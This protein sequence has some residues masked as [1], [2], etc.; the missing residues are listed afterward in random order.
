MRNRYIVV[1]LLVLTALTFVGC[2]RN[3]EKAK[4]KYLDSGMKYMDNKQYEAASIQ[5][6][7]AIQVDPKFAEA[8]YQ[9]AE[10]S[11]KLEHWGEGFREMSQAVELDPNNLKA[12]IAL[13]DF[14]LAGGKYPEAEEQAKAILERDPNNAD[15]YRLLGAVQ[16][17]QKQIPEAI[18]SYTKAIAAEAR[19]GPGAYLNRG[20]AYASS[21]QMPEAE[22]DFRKAISV[23]PKNLDA[24]ASL[25]RFYVFSGHADKAIEVLQQGIKANPDEPANYLRLASIV[26][27]IGAGKN[28]AETVLAEPAQ[29]QAQLG[30]SRR[31]NRRF[32]SGS[33]QPRSCHSGI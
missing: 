27:R 16:L 13:G 9:L 17:A 28:D 2:R 23:D 21:N 30:R 33:A 7:K 15:G 10:A 5:F 3:P 24:Y 1:F 32:L 14:Y 4:Q 12:R 6:K 31:G 18:A 26:H 20:I 19:S 29:H 22:A 25:A 8:H 11:L